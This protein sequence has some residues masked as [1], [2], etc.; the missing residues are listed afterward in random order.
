M[1]LRYF[2]IAIKSLMKYVVLE[3]NIDG[4]QSKNLSDSDNSF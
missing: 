1:K 4:L 2:S 3:K